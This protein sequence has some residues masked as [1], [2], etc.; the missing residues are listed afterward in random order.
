[1]SETDDYIHDVT[2]P[3]QF[4]REMTPAWIDA[5]TRGLGHAMPD[6]AQPFRWCELGCGTGLNSLVAAATHPR[7]EFVAID[8]NARH[9]D[10]ARAAATAAGL[11]NLRVIHAGF[12]AWDGPEGEPLEPFDAIVTHGVLS[13]ISRPQRQAFFRFVARFLR[14]GGIVYAHYMTHPG[15]SAAAAAQ[16]LARRYGETLAGSSAERARHSLAFLSRLSEAGAGFYAAYPQEKLRLASAARQ[17]GDALAHELLT[18]GWEPFHVATM[19]EEFA[20]AGCTYRGSATP[21]DNIDAVSLPAATRPLLA[22][23]QA[24][25]VAETVRDMARNQSLRRDLYQRGGGPL[26]PTRHMEAL[27]AL[28]LAALPGAPSGGQDLHF[29]TPIGRVSGDRALF[30]P[31][32][33]ALAQAPRTV[34]E[35]ARLPGFSPH[36]AILNQAVQMLLWSA[37]AHPV[38]R[39]LP[40]PAAA[41]AL[42]RHLARDDGPGWL[43]APALGTAL[44]ATAE[45]MAMARAALESPAAEVPPGMRAL[46]DRWTAFGVL[47]PRH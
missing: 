2:Y 42:N 31:I 32:L 19:M 22:G 15:L 28:A 35:L 10:Q 36:P 5:V 3:A 33:D 39:A 47:P 26:S 34:A 40:D 6:I 8:A 9:V 24:P 27:G 16:H 41:W 7:A 23:I 11:R 20:A 13:W 38:A 1:M 25:S 43:V 44:P 37:C 14:P 29:D 30:G 21:A 46:R 4:H 17:D 45:A 12:D 18:A